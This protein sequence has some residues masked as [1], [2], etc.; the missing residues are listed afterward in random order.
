ME[1]MHNSLEDDPSSLEII[2]DLHTHTVYSHGKG[3][4]ADNA[5]QGMR[6]GL[7]IIAITDHGLRHVLFGLRKRKLEKLREDIDAFNVA[8]EGKLKVLLGIEAN[9]I[10]M[11]GTI[12]V[13]EKL[14]SFF[15]ILLVGL[16]AGVL[17]KGIRSM[18]HFLIASPFSFTKKRRALAVDRNTQALVRAMHRYPID[19]ITHPNMGF[20]VNMQPICQAAA[21]TQTGLEISVKHSGLTA[22]MLRQCKAWGARFVISTDAHKPQDV[23]KFDVAIQRA[24]EAGLTEADIYNT[25]QNIAKL[26]SW[27]R[28][29]DGRKNVDE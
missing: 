17:F 8:H 9:V 2:A 21:A 29:A 18:Y 24:L 27:R 5:L 10:H 25:H 16:H 15:D 28:R 1:R 20:K 13:P 23:G 26:K 7:S 6:R 14:L 3:S 12:D 4:V 11:D 19:F 22:D